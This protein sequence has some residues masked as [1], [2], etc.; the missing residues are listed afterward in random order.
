MEKIP[1]DASF[2]NRVKD[3]FQSRK[4]REI[5]LNHADDGEKRSFFNY[6]EESSADKCK[7]SEQRKGMIKKRTKRNLLSPSRKHFDSDLVRE[8]R[9][10]EQE[11]LK[12]QHQ[13]LKCEA[14][15]TRP[16]ECEFIY[17]KFKS[18][19]KEV[20]E[21][22]DQFVSDNFEEIKVN[23]LDTSDK[24]GKVQAAESS[25]RLPYLS[26][27]NENVGQTYFGDGF[28]SYTYD[29]IPRFH[30]DLD[31]NFGDFGNQREKSNVM[32]KSMSR[33]DPPFN[34]FHSS[35]PEVPEIKQI[36]VE[37]GKNIQVKGQEPTGEK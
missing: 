17:L 32:S 37:Q 18:F 10:A 31:E 4:R 21:K 22:F 8:K 35:P 14:G 33:N 30:E 24:N 3:I 13:Y 27:N 25:N 26:K 29:Q 7:A 6:I 28:Y 23:D 5:D 16:E 9:R 19:A 12:L 20:N 36:K 15:A 11:L 1:F 2:L 34:Q